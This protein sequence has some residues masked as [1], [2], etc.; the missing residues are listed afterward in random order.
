MIQRC[1][2]TITVDKMYYEWSEKETTEFIEELFESGFFKM[3][4]DLTDLAVISNY[5]WLYDEE[6][7]PQSFITA[8]RYISSCHNFM[9]TVKDH[10]FYLCHGCDIP[11]SE[12]ERSNKRH[13][14]DK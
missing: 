4:V 9:E 12:K 3:N 1:I 11:M 10:L 5:A 7:K 2:N 8:L 6:D 13:K 14:K